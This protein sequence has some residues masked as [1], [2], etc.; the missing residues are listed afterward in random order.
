M[1]SD[2]KKVFPEL[3]RRHGDK[4]NGPAIRV[5]LQAL[6]RRG[7][8]EHAVELLRTAIREGKVEPWMYEALAYMLRLA[9]HPDSEVEAALLSAADTLDSSVPSLMRIADQLI[10]FKRYRAALGLVRRAGALAPLSP[11]PFEKALVLGVKLGDAEAVEWAATHLLRN[12]WPDRHFE[13]HFRAH[14][15]VEEMRRQLLSRGRQRE[16]EELVR[17]VTEADRRDLVISVSWEGDADVDVRI[18]EPPGTEC[19]ALR[20]RTP[21]GGVLVRDGVGENA[22]ETYICPEAFPGTYQVFTRCVWGKVRGDRVRIEVIKWQGTDQETREVYYATVGQA[23]P[24]VIEL[25]RGRRSELVDVP[26]LHI[27]E[28]SDG[29][30]SMTLL[31]PLARLDQLL[32]ASGGEGRYKGPRHLYQ[33]PLGSAVAYQPIPAPVFDGAGMAVQAV[34]TADRRYVRLSIAPFFTNVIGEQR[35]PVFATFR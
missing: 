7:A 27:E 15:A 10:A 9:G 22:T 32:A 24:V 1:N 4:L 20:K 19:S 26:V 31:G 30:R 5:L 18:V 13:L 17:A 3:F 34:I 16:A 14:A 2:P 25:D 21:A 35:F 8:Y 12:A 29:T 6:A 33:F 23:E 11:E 28:A